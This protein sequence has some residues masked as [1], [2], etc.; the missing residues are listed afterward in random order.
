ME[1]RLEDLIQIIL[2]G[3]IPALQWNEELYQNY[4]NNNQFTK[5]LGFVETKYLRYDSRHLFRASIWPSVY[6]L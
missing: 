5:D 4:A 1:V 3:V 2:K 6:G